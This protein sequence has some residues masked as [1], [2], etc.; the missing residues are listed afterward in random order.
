MW[1]ACYDDYRRDQDINK[2][3]WQGGI[4]GFSG[5][6]ML[7]RYGWGDASEARFAVEKLSEEKLSVYRERMEQS[8]RR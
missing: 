1:D 8:D 6:E 5:C 2:H 7:E 4:E 3:N